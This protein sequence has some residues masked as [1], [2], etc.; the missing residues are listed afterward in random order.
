ITPKVLLKHSSVLPKYEL[1]T[2]NRDAAMR[3]RSAE[4]LGL[5]HPLIDALIAQCQ[6]ITMTGD[7]AV[8]PR[9]VIDQEPYAVISTLITVDLEGGKQH[10]ELKTVRISSTGDAHVMSDEW[11]MNRLEKRLSEVP[12]ESSNN[13]F[14]WDKIRQSYEGAIGAILSQIKTSLEKPVGARVRLLG[15]SAVE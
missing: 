8:F 10:K 3:K 7:V 6:E 11:L 9:T 13:K 14:P 2:F 4:L 12:T 1:A 5:G 15:V